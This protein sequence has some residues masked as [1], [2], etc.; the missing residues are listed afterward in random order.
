MK[1]ITLSLLFAFALFSVANAQKVVTKVF[2]VKEAIKISTVSGDCVIKISDGNEIKVHLSYTYDDDCFSYKFNEKSD[3]LEIKEEFDGNCS[4]KSAWTITIPENTR[5]KF[6]SASGDIEIN[7][8]TNSI[9]VNTASGDIKLSN[10]KGKIKLNTASGDV[11]LNTINS[12]LKL[13]T[14][15]GDI[16]A[17]NLDGKIKIITASG[18]VDINKANG[19]LYVNSASGEIEAKN[20]NGNIKINTASGDIDIENAKGELSVNSASGEIEAAQIEISGESSFT[21]AS[22]DVE[23]SLKKSTTYDLTLS[24]ASGDVTLNNN[25]NKLYGYYEFTAR[26]KKGKIVSPIKFDKEEVIEKN[27][28]KYDVKSFSKGKS[29]PIILI[30]TSS[31]RAKLVK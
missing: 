15:S 24:S 13:N 20:L 10:L 3:H 31:G 19:E 16:D 11:K 21:T 18:D 28:K 1:K 27:G 8:V 7:G 29:S 25:G 9:D 14:A 12:N 22:G 4:G 26:V 30:K 23:L 6:N 17:E 2:E 5:V